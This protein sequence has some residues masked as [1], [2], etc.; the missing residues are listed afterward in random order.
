MG[1]KLKPREKKFIK[2]ITESLI[3]E[4]KTAGV[5]QKEMA[6]MI[7]TTQPSISVGERGNSWTNTRKIYEYAEALNLKVEIVFTPK[8]AK[9]KQSLK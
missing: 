5:S 3:R 7:G 2:Q 9:T 4:R 6:G 1:K 8:K